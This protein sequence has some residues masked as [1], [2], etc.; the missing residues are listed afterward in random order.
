MSNTSSCLELAYNVI[1]QV[2]GTT[3][4]AGIVKSSSLALKILAFLV[5]CHYR[6]IIMMG[7]FVEL[8]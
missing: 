1:K 2:I 3:T 5:A 6:L 4:F 7:I 8:A